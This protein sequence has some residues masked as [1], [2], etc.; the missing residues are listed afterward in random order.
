MSLRMNKI[1]FF[2]NS[3]GRLQGQDDNETKKQ[4]VYTISDMGLPPYR[5]RTFRLNWKNQLLWD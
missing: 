2:N 5:A 3:L 1:F 4:E